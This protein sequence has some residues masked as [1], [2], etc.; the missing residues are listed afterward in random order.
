[1]LYFG[2]VLYIGSIVYFFILAK[3]LAIELAADNIPSGDKKA[4]KSH[5]N[6][7]FHLCN[8]IS[9]GILAYEYLNS[10]NYQQFDTYFYAIAFFTITLYAIT[11]TILAMLRKYIF[12]IDIKTPQD[13]DLFDE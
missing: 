7:I 5:G 2:L 9:C 12:K 13:P 4:Q 8:L 11:F 1:M 6:K 3:R 10:I